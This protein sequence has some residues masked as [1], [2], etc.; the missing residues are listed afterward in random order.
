MK[1]IFGDTSAFFALVDKTERYHEKAIEMSNKIAKEKLEIVISDHILSETITLVRGKI[2]F[3]ES[4]LI[5]K[6]LLDSKIT[7]LVIINEKILNN[8]WDIFLK[9]SDKDFS[10]IDCISF[11]VMEQEGIDTAFTFDHHFEQIG[12]KILKKE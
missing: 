2:G 8:A 12:F 9:Y 7:T 10:F 4:L 1:R 5:G 6:K 3:R 11:A